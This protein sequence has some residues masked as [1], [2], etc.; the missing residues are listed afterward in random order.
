MTPDA[1]LATEIT[2]LFEEI[3]SQ[4]AAV[5]DMDEKSTCLDTA[6]ANDTFHQSINRANISIYGTPSSGTPINTRRS[7]VSPG[8][9]FKDMTQAMEKLSVEN[10]QLKQQMEQQLKEQADKI[11]EVTKTN[12]LQNETIAKLTSML[13]TMMATRHFTL[14]LKTAILMS[15]D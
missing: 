8:K 3:N 7:L 13:Q 14:L 12:E 10:Q 1:T 2:D 4:I 9:H 11:D 15:S 5:S 6:E